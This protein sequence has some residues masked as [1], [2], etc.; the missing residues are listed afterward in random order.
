MSQKVLLV[1]CGGSGIT[2]LLRFNAL[3]AGNPEWRNLLWEDVS[4]MV[5]DTE[6]AKTSGFVEAVGRQLG[7]AK[8]PIMRMVQITSGIHR[9][10]DVVRPNIDFQ[11]DPEKLARLEP[12]WWHDSNGNPFRAQKISN[13]ENGAGQCG[14]VSYL[15]TWNFLPRLEAEI[16]GILKEVQTHNIGQNNPLEKIRVFIVAG[17]AGG[18]GRG[19]WNLIAFKIRQ[20]L[21]SRGHQVEPTGI[22]FDATCFSNVVKNDPDQDI[23]TRLN[24][25]TALSELSAWMN[26]C[27]GHEKYHYSLPNLADPD[28]AGGTDVVRVDPKGRVNSRQSPI[29][30]AYLICGSNGRGN[31]GN[32]NAYHEMVAA[33]LYSFVAGGHFVDPKTINRMTSFGSLAAS[34]FEV[35][36]V[37]L[38][39][40][41]EST[42]RETSIKELLRKADK[43]SDAEKAALAFIGAPGLGD[44]SFFDSIP[45][46]VDTAVSVSSVT[47]PA[48]GGGETSL[49]QSI[50]SKVKT[51]SPKSVEV[52]DKKLESQNVKAAWAQAMLG[53]SMSGL[54]K[55]KLNELVEESLAELGI[56]DLRS[57]LIEKIK[58][59]YAATSGKKPSLGRARRVVLGLKKTFEASIENLNSPLLS[60]REAYKKVEDVSACFKR[61][62]DEAA[63]KGFLEF[64]PF[65]NP[66]RRML[67]NSFAMHQN[68]AV[69][70][71]IK[72]LL[73]R[74]FEE[75]RTVLDEI[76]SALARLSDTLEDVVDSFSRDAK[77]ECG[78]ERGGS[79]YK[80][81]FVDEK[82]T[83]VFNS[84]PKAD[85][86]SNIYRRTLKPI[87]SEDKLWELLSKEAGTS[88][89]EK[90][91]EKINT[92][93]NIL[94]EGSEPWTDDVKD[95]LQKEF[96]A[97]FQTNVFLKKDFLDKNFSFEGVLRNNLK[98]WNTLIQE[99]V[100]IPDQF[101]LLSD[102]L[103]VFL[104]VTG[105]T[106]S[107]DHV[108]TIKWDGLLDGILVSMV[109]TCKPW[110]EFAGDNGD[111][112]ETIA[113][114]P[115]TIEQAGEEEK[116]RKAIEKNHKTQE[117]TIVH[118]GL[119]SEGGYKLP[120]DRIVV[121][122][123]QKLTKGDRDDHLLDG[124]TSF[125]YWRDAKVEKR[126]Q[127]A[128]SADGAAFFEPNRNGTGFIERERGLGYISP[129]FVNDP[130]L[131]TLRWK[132][133]APK[134]TVDAAK[135]RENQ[136][137]SALL[138]AMLGNG[139][140]AADPLVKTLQDQYNWPLPLITIGGGKSRRFSYTRDPLV[141]KRGKGAPDGNPAWQPEEKLVT[142]IDKVFAFLSGSG[143][144]EL[145]AKGKTHLEHLILEIGVFNKNI[146]T[147]IGKIAFVALTEA[148][149]SW[150][151]AQCKKA[152]DTDQVFWRKL[153]EAAK[154]ADAED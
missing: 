125:S 147:D 134:E 139:L 84:L 149:R 136:V 37:R 41:F 21:E 121:F 96:K 70:F 85:D 2:T 59:A 62:F 117:T 101:D 28:P 126:L 114:L 38:R 99:T 76:E 116:L 142:G 31:L 33:A 11:K 35:D 137:C 22:F 129:L 39:T 66:E 23:N 48:Q 16:D 34:T 112:L 87:Y 130:R 64:K 105:L 45:F 133:W 9:L 25:L 49:L 120:L 56:S 98:H 15:C 36:T 68:Y 65:T 20:Y 14:P 55:E 82:S 143:E 52:F 95:S 106:D 44:D 109:G 104:G 131:S 90:I 50:I 67:A 47:P 127:L 140:D 13:L 75:A 144:A 32:N 86:V 141:W 89:R 29:S 57:L 51:D 93:L 19:S 119:E 80:A 146:R 72:P 79:A 102:R 54:S 152:S 111:Y 24:S 145:D 78:A 1:G 118:R 122:A 18:T 60:G 27:D 115:V 132:P 135:E 154:R 148:R 100:G 58:E 91:N 74:K 7:S 94:L 151:V 63:K 123:S 92:E 12:H 108:P 77:K 103:R 110:I 3:M 26:L 124:V 83:E 42:L 71:K 5:V 17:M 107:G 61:I 46:L 43:G 81:L 113:L 97:L 88:R 128:E 8:N 40:Y 153:Q 4:Y 138:Y 73:I 69:F 150:L 10:D 6:V 30:S 53:L